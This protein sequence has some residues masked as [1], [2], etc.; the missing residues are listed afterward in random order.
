[1]KPTKIQRLEELI[2]ELSQVLEDLVK[3]DRKVKT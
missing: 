2:G 3:T 1:M